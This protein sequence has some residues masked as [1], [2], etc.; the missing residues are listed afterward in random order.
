MRNKRNGQL[1][2]LTE[3]H[4]FIHKNTIVI[5]FYIYVNEC[6]CIYLEIYTAIILE[7]KHVVN[8]MENGTDTLIVGV[9]K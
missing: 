8:K 4:L 1:G 7:L 5:Q 3:I 9:T 2:K 6:I